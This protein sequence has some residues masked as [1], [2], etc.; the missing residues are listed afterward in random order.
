MDTT[1]IQSFAYIGQPGRLYSREPVYGHFLVL[2][3]IYPFPYEM[4]Q[5]VLIPANLFAGD[6]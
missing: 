2:L 4:H 5:Q 3:F 6:R 1:K